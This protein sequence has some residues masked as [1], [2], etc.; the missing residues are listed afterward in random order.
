MFLFF[1]AIEISRREPKVSQRC[2]EKK[3]P[4]S[5]G[6]R[7]F[8]RILGVFEKALQFLGI[9]NYFSKMLTIVSIMQKESIYI[10]GEKGLIC[11]E[12]LK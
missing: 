10:K 2:T 7:G 6:F 5:T 4:I 11:T 3:H 1:F 12:S 9:L 8:Q